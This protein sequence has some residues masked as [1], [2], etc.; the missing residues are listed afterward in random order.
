MLLGLLA[1]AP[2]AEG[3]SLGAIVVLA[4]GVLL[5]LIGFLLAYM[6]FERRLGQLSRDALAR[7][8]PPPAE[9][10]K[11]EPAIPAVE[12]PRVRCPA[13]GR[14]Y[15]AS[16]R[17]CPHD[18]KPLVAVTGQPVR[19]GSG[20]ICPTCKRA[21]DP[22]VKFCPQDS[23]ELVPMA[24]WQATNAKGAAPEC[25]AKI[26]PACA[27]KYEIDATFCGKDGSALVPVN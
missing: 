17:F 2:V 18:S 14:E 8:Q 19:G 6:L 10:A 5:V 9:P 7:A 22:G 24:F 11:S 23:D 26:C 21:F 4:M 20:G 16:V 13:C 12:Q 27:A 1:E 25:G 15:E 3:S